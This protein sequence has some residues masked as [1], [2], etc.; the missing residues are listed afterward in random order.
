MNKF[1]EQLMYNSPSF[2]LSEKQLM[3]DDVYMNDYYQ[4]QK[5]EEIFNILS[6]QEE[7]KEE[8]QEKQQKEEEQEEKQ[9][10]RIYK[11]NEQN[12][13]RKFK[14]LERYI[15]KYGKAPVSTKGIFEGV[16]IYVWMKNEERSYKNKIQTPEQTVKFENIMRIAKK[17]N[18]EAMDER[19][20]YEKY[21]IYV[22]DK[23]TDTVKNWIYRQKRK[24]ETGKLKKVYKDL[25]EQIPEWNEY[26]KKMN[27]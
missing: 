6:F 3:I 19:Q 17:Y 5:L 1:E 9:N 23:N 27:V 16:N 15:E 11:R 12:W 10:K 25:L 18:R 26:V 20:W 2:F 22:I 13:T 14:I 7:Q 8:Q 4:E 24:N 21:K